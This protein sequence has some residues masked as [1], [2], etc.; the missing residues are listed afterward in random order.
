MRNGRVVKR[1]DEFDFLT[2]SSVQR[3]SR[4]RRREEVE[5]DE[6]DVKTEPPPEPDSEDAQAQVMVEVVAT[7]EEIDMCQVKRELNNENNNRLD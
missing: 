4:K 2:I 5:D 7:V 6:A 1:G 3:K